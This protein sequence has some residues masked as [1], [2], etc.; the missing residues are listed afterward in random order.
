MASSEPTTLEYAAEPSAQGELEDDYE[1][2]PNSGRRR[3]STPEREEAAG[4]RGVGLNS[5]Q[6]ES[7][8]R[9]RKAAIKGQFTRA[10]RGLLVQLNADGPCDIEGISQHLEGL[11]A[12][13]DGA[14]SLL[15][16]M[17]GS[18]QDVRQRNKLAS[19]LEALETQFSA[20]MDR[21][22]AKIDVNKLS[23]AHPQ[24]PSQGRTDIISSP[25]EDTV[26]TLSGSQR[27]NP[28]ETVGGK[29]IVPVSTST[30]VGTRTLDATGRASAMSYTSISDL[31]LSSVSASP[32]QSVHDT[33]LPT[34]APVTTI[35]GITGSSSLTAA[36]TLTTG[37]SMTRP[38]ASLAAP[39]SGTTRQPSTSQAVASSQPA[40]SSSRLNAG[41]SV[42][43]PSAPSAL[44]AASKAWPGGATSP[45]THMQRIE[46]PTFAGDKRSFEAWWAAFSACVDKSPVSPEC[47][48]LRLRQ[49]LSGEP[50]RTIKSLGYTAASYEAAKDMLTRKYGGERR[51][52]AIQLEEIEEMRPI[53]EGK[54]RE[55]QQ[56]AEL[57]MVATVQL[58]EAGRH[59]ELLVGTLYHSLMKKLDERIIARYHRWRY[60]HNRSES[61]ECLLEFVTLEA[62]LLVTAAETVS[63]FNTAAKADQPRSS[64]D[65]RA[66]TLLTGTRNKSSPSKCPACQSQHPVW[67][68]LVFKS[69]TLD[70]RWR[71]AKASNLCFRCLGAGHRGQECTWGDA[72]GISGCSKSHHRLLHNAEKT[73][74]AS[75]TDTA[76][77]DSKPTVRQTLATSVEG[78]QQRSR[79]TSN[80]RQSEPAMSLVTCQTTDDSKALSTASKA[81]KLIAVSMRTVP[82][83][84]RSGGKEVLVNAL[85]DDASTDSYV[86]SHVACELGLT[87]ERQHLPVKVLS[88][89]TEVFSTTHVT[90]QLCSVDGETSATLDAFTTD[91]ILGSDNAVD[92]VHKRRDWAHLR[93][94]PFPAL[95]N[96]RQ[97]DVLLGLDAVQLQAAIR[98]V[99]GQPGE[100]IARLTPLGWT[101]VGRIGKVKADPVT[102]LTRAA[103]HDVRESI[104]RLWA[105]E[106]FGQAQPQQPTLSVEEKEA[107]QA[108]RESMQWIADGRYQVGIPWRAGRPTL[109]DNF[110]A[111]LKRLQST[112]RRL[113][114][115]AAAA[116]AYSNIVLDYVKKGYVRE[117]S[118]SELKH[119]QQW[120]LPHF[121]V[122][123]PDKATTKTRMVFDASAKCKGIAL[124]DTMLPGPKL[125]R[126]LPNVL[127]RFRHKPVGIICDIAEMYLQ[128][129]LSPEDRPYHRFLWR[130]MEP[131]AEPRVYEFERLVFGANASPF[132]AQF[133]YQEHAR[134]NRH[135]YPLAAETML[136]STY[137]DDSMDSA[138]DPN[139]GVEMYEQL[140]ACWKEAGMHARKWLSN[141]KVVMEKVPQQDRAS[142][143]DVSCPE[144]PSVKTL[145]LL[146]SAA[147]DSFTFKPNVPDLSKQVTKRSFLS[148]TAS[149]FDP[150]G[151]VG[152]YVVS[153]R[154]LIQDMWLL[155]LDWD[156]PLPDVLSQR[157]TGWYADLAELSHLSI[158]RCLQ[159]VEAGSPT[160]RQIH[161]FTD[162]SETAYGAVSYLRCVYDDGHV[163]TA[164]IASRARVAP[165][166]AISIPRLELLAAVMGMQLAIWSSDVLS[167]PASEAT[168]WTDSLNVLYWIRNRARSFKPFIATRIGEIQQST[169]PSQWRHVPTKVNPADVLSRGSSAQALIHNELWWSAPDFLRKE[170]VEWPAQQLQE[171]KSTVNLEK[172]SADP[173]G[174]APVVLAT[175]AAEAEAPWS[176]N[177]TRFS[178]INRLVRRRAWVMRFVQNCSKP[179]ELRETGPLSSDELASSRA[180]VIAAAQEESL[181]EY[182][183]VRDG[184]PIPASSKLAKLRPMLNDDRLLC[185]DSRLRNAAI[186]DEQA[187]CPVILPRGHWVTQLIVKEA[188]EKNRHA[189]GISHTLS[190][191][192]Q[193]Y[194]LL[195]GREEIKAWE[196]KCAHCQRQAAKPGTQIMAPLPTVRV[197]LPLRAFSRVAVDY[198]RPFTTKQGRGKPRAK[199]YLC[200]FT[201]LQSRAVHLEMATSLDVDGFMNAFLRMTNRRGVPIQVV[202]DNGTNFVGAA[203]EMKK[204][205]KAM[206][207]D[208]QRRAADKGI[209]W[210]FNPPAA[211]H[212]GGVH[213]ALVKSAKRAIFA[214][215]AGAEVNDE[216]LATAITGAEALLNSRPLTYQ[217]A[218]AR[219]LLPLTNHFLYGHQGQPF[220]P[221]G[222][223]IVPHS[224][225]YRWRVVQSLVLQVWK[226][227]MTELL[228][229]LHTRAKW[230]QPQPDIAVNDVVLVVNTGTPRGKWKLGRVEEV[231]PGVDGRVRVAK[232][233]VGD[234]SLVR[235]IAQMCKLSSE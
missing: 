11:T 131:T 223:D 140:S 46:I 135:K 89:R 22:Q 150:L 202:S 128:V 188:H 29:T 62:E 65:H 173:S 235:P 66:R 115:D 5:A 196:K 123:R 45:W 103:P 76:S 92:W 122:L 117:V 53:R 102:C 191:L 84:L 157:V 124:N 3:S 149:V 232:V 48:M 189:G 226:R 147:T 201:C 59:A 36:T 162:A 104:A 64:Q 19:E 152:P 146:W 42:Y 94:I 114:Q 213:E 193:K 49:Y 126:Q 38:L 134:T 228:P 120:F 106:E 178:D 166:A 34:S 145:G 96:R 180:S 7:E 71:I 57:L 155:A 28:T 163:S 40:F 198:A 63:G 185:V 18:C 37:T 93:N 204:L 112:E 179:M 187:R 224:H 233:K 60:D 212:F 86:S 186:L 159:A 30:Q 222:T 47:K 192:S 108:A 2:R 142:Q 20:A 70:E 170:E 174:Q 80:S 107:M 55:L 79:T 214:I 168:I 138:T 73:S 82:V 67:R 195:A 182:R 151:F 25:H 211:P 68:C 52:L 51:R 143:I 72:C 26:Y 217:S 208:V 39:R 207:G 194:W 105:I 197:S 13:Y 90:V 161:V 127:T 12:L 21:A 61:V 227:W 97:V 132:L 231:Y 58:K 209:K 164:L 172:K 234:T 136:H 116:T 118:S 111:A 125:Q 177:P 87:G 199:R 171:P 119:G 91:S 221:K 88:G 113:S 54:P 156:E 77:E 229:L 69:A 14:T 158:P 200:L 32:V 216:E 220:V 15:A 100:P 23:E 141:S 184:K 205:L 16:D 130:G 133:V 121:A 95:P 109:P 24:S 129:H 176:L 75:G 203:N 154:Q 4:D 101:C 33:V 225:R 148:A 50:L 1:E 8:L 139:E 206:E 31:S 9:V 27:G 215:L 230:R 167:L 10:R 110:A 78:K 160:S 35:N 190:D 181:E 175:V 169:S 98:E 56:F 43:V 153:A 85:L 218:D 137:M 41:A 17:I 219:D 83:K 6:V 74:S 144:L 183:L 99:H 81:S 165:L 44:P 210:S